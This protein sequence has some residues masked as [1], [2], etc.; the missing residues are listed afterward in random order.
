MVGLPFAADVPSAMRMFCFVAELEELNVSRRTHM[1]EV[2]WR[3]LNR[4]LLSTVPAASIRSSLFCALPH[5]HH[6]APPLLGLLSP[7]QSGKRILRRLQRAI[8]VF[9]VEQGKCFFFL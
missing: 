5:D 1:N 4:Q 7:S 9:I 3:T 6:P 2:C 8:W